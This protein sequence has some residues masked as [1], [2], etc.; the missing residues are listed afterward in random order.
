MHI[1]LDE[2][3][4]FSPVAPGRHSLS[5]V[6]ALIVPGGKLPLLLKKYMKLRPTLP[7]DAAGEVKGKLLDE[8]HI[9]QVCEVLLQTDCLFEAATVDMGLE[10]LDAIRASRMR[11]AVGFTATLTGEHYP[12]AFERA[13][14]LRKTMAGMAIPLYVQ[15]IVT[16]E[17]LA[18]VLY[19]AP[20]YYA[21]WRP[22]EL[23]NFDWVIDGK[24]V[25]KVTSAEKWWSDAMLPLLEHRSLRQPMDIFDGGDYSYFLGKFGRSTPEHLQEFVHHDGGMVN[26][27][28]IME[29]FR[30]SS[31]P[32]PGLE[33]ADIVT[34]ATRRALHGHL[35]RDGWRLLPCLMLNRDRQYLKIVSFAEPNDGMGRPYAEVVAGFSGCGRPLVRRSRVERHLQGKC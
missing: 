1:Y 35:G 21:Q 20:L 26:L 5:V 17:V 25:G 3:G 34:N 19:N 28:K 13:W 27:R 4:T 23:E 8:H 32:E 14:Y 31:N 15:S 10:T 7:K 29:S 22:R 16:F 6:G 24:E 12:W 11:R 2:S 9:S 33:L 18:N 30:F